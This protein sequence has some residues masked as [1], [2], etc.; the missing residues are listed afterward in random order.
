LQIVRNWQNEV[1]LNIEAAA[2]RRI[3]LGLAAFAMVWAIVRA[4]VQA[5]TIDE[6]VTYTNFVLPRDS[7]FWTPHAN[8]HILNSVLMRIFTGIFGT[9]HLTVRSGALIGAAVFILA[10]YFLSALVNQGFLLRAALFVCLVF[11]PFIFDFL[12]AARGYGLASGFLLSAICLMAYAK[13]PPGPVAFRSL[14]IACIWASICI[15]LSVLSNFSFAFVDAAAIVILYLWA[16]AGSLRTAQGAA[17]AVASFLPCLLMA[18]ALAPLLLQWKEP[19]IYGAHHLSETFRSLREAS[20]YELNPSLTDLI[21]IDVPGVIL[22]AFAIFAIWRG[23]LM[24]V[25]WRS[26]RSPQSRWA[27]ALAAVPLL[28][29]AAAVFMHWAVFRFNR[30]P[31]P[32]DRTGIYVVV[33]ITLFVGLLAAIP[34]PTRAGETSRRGLTIL[35]VILGSYFL[36]C[37]RMSYFKEWKF[38]ADADKVYS[39]LAYYNHACGLKDIPVSWRYDGSLNFYRAVSGRENI[40]EFSPALTLAPPQKYVAGRRAYVV[41][42]PDDLDFIK[43]HAL[44]VVY[45]A[46][47]GAAIAMDPEVQPPAGESACPPKPPDPGQ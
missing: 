30:T 2:E 38:D 21:F 6:A 17:L 12:V 4:R 25:H 5:I 9:S 26:L 35:M 20:F 34:I 46:S 44:R 45:Q 42:Q 32:K 29:A 37:L 22:P 41:Y 3:L 7:T 10:S 33:L 27:L 14:V 19:L 18:G 23:V 31:L 36:L 11:N 40:H 16:S 28:A 15:V 43:D 8:N 13:R 24:I 1:V 47:S 39:V